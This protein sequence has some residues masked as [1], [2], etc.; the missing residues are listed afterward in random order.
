VSEIKIRPSNPY[1]FS[2]EELSELAE[3]IRQEDPT[4]EVEVDSLPEQGYGVTPVEVIAII[5]ATG[6]S[7][8]AVKETAKAAQTAINWM[9]KR[10]QKDKE[11]AVGPP[12][13]RTVRILYGPDGDELKS[14]TIDEPDGSPEEQS[15]GHPEEKT[16]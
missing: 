3:E 1:D 8:A 6:G 10:W 5:T 12:R 13:R 2:P 9:R 14:V 4:V 16:K 15:G 11:K 7:V